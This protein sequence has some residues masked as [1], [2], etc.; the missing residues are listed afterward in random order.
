MI[1]D[2]IWSSQGFVNRIPMT[3][4]VT[5]KWSVLVCRQMAM[6]NIQHTMLAQVCLSTLTFFHIVV[7]GTCNMA[8]ALLELCQFMDLCLFHAV[9][10]GVSWMWRLIHRRHKSAWRWRS[11]HQSSLCTSSGSSLLRVLGGTRNCVIVWCVVS[12]N[13]PCVWNPDCV[14]LCVCVMQSPW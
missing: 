4:Q 11:C 9:S 3:I 1:S 6:Y 14:L 5:I 10:S 8:Y 2:N 7:L 13:F 12:M